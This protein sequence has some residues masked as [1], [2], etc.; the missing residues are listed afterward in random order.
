MGLFT[1]DDG[2]I[3]IGALYLQIVGPIYGCYGLGMALYFATQGFGSVIWTVTA[4]AV[5]LLASTGCALIAI[6]WLD[7]GATGL[8]VA[9]AAGFCAY[10]ALTVAALVNVKRSSFIAG[11]L[12]C[13]IGLAGMTQAFARPVCRPALTFKEVRFSPMQMPTFERR[14]TA[15][16]SVD[17]SRCAAKTAGYFE[18]GFLRLAEH[19]PDAEFQEQFIWLAPEVTVS[20]DFWA[21][22][23]VERYWVH[24]VP[25]CRC[26][27]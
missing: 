27:D 10:A 8:F 4:N 5:R 1:A 6:S 19:A 20:V 12:V 17:A 16:V 26:R 2:I 21:D 15:V 23:A 3:R 14:W 25:A 11:L 24:S 7:R 18:I 22:E 13:M 9:I